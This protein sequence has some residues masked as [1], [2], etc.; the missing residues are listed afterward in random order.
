VA[1]PRVAAIVPARNEASR[2]SATVAALRSIGEIG[3]VIVVDD[4]SADQTRRLAT[5]AGARTIRVDHR[6]GKGAALALGASQTDAEILLFADADLAETARE[7]RR[8]IEPILAGTADLAIASLPRRE[9]PSGFGLVEG[10]ARW[11]IRALTGRA[12]E[13]PL[14][15]QRAMRREVLGAVSPLAYGFGVEVGMTVDALRAGFRVIEVA[16]DMD[17]ARTGRTLEGFAHRAR[18][19]AHVGAALLKRVARKGVR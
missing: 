1:G 7:A 14:S 4:G 19:G 15:G 12:T 3:E 11:G 10:A 2:I 17:H 16:C 13:R 9:G 18:Q 8:L 5:E 6:L